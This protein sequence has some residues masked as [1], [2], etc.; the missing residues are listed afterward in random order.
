MRDALKISNQKQK[1][2]PDKFVFFK[3]N[4]AF[5]EMHYSIPGSISF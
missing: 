5:I 4:G 1:D 3:V 2:N